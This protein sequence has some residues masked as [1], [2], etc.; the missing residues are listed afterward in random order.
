MNDNVTELALFKW[1]ESQNIPD[2]Y[3]NI[4]KIRSFPFSS[5][6]RCSATIVSFEGSLYLYLK[7]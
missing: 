3:K 1:V 6:N 7:G 5:K 4:E 2:T